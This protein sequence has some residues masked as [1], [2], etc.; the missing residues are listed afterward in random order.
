MTREQDQEH[1]T[2][3]RT[4]RRVAR[5]SLGAAAHRH[6]P[7]RRRAAPPDIIGNDARSLGIAMVLTATLGLIVTT[8]LLSKR[9]RSES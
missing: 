8:M 4:A 5:H 3:R 2:Q 1:R 6:P 9:H 7:A